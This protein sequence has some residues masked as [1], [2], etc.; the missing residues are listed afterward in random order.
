MNYLIATHGTLASG[1]KDSLD[2]IMGVPKNLEVFQMT[3][4]KSASDAEEEVKK[5][6]DHKKGRGLIVF[7]DVFGGSVANLFTQFLLEGYEFKLVTGVN[8]PMLLTAILEGETSSSAEAVKKSIQEGTQGIQFINEKIKEVN[9][10]DIS[11]DED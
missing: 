5:L 11:F 7:T 10:N 8:L 6:L 2:L 3:K 4:E 9:N 1:F